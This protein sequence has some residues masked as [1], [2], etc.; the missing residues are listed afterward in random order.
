[1]SYVSFLCLLE[2]RIPDRLKVV[3]FWGNSILFAI[4]AGLRSGINMPDYT[5]YQSLYFDVIDSTS[6]YLIEP[7][8]QLIALIANFINPK[9]PVALFIIYGL[10][11][12]LFKNFLILRFSI[13]LFLA[14]LVYL[15]NYFII[16][17][18]IQ[19]R[20]G[21]A[22]CFIALAIIK[23]ATN[24]KKTAAILI[25]I[26]TLCHYSS[27]VFFILLLVNFRGV[28]ARHVWGLL[29]LSY[30]L[31]LFKIDPITLGF[32]FIVEYFTFVKSAYLD[33]QRAEEFSINIF[34][35]FILTK[36]IIAL[37]FLF[38]SSHTTI[39]NNIYFK[40]S[41]VSFLLGV[42]VYIAL[43]RFPEIAVRIAYTLMFFEVFLIPFIVRM[44]KPH[45]L[46]TI[47]VILFCWTSF[48]ANVFL[49]HYFSYIP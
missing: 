40:I 39:S 45:F 20:A 41:F 24:N 44:F 29:F 33:L 25:G 31:Y 23:I 28:G 16:H 34:G 30:C 2:S 18:L 42:C 8:F 13:P 11:S 6:F 9:E 32:D 37:F 22:T 1:M 47:A 14:Q 5:M 38:S 35:I 12:V 48:F 10:V 4:V 19:I 36:I 17:E 26:A 21:F 46:A 3:I 7:S 27:F 15:S 49:T 43:A